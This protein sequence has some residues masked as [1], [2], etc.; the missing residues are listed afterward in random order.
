[1][2]RKFEELEG[3]TTEQYALVPGVAQSR[4]ETN[5]ELPNEIWQTV[6]DLFGADFRPR[7]SLSQVNKR[8]NDLFKISPPQIIIHKNTVAQ[9]ILNLRRISG[10]TFGDA[11]PSLVNQFD[12]HTKKTSLHMMSDNRELIRNAEIHFLEELLGKN[13]EILCKNKITFDVFVLKKNGM[14]VQNEIG[15]YYKDKKGVA[16]LFLIPPTYNSHQGGEIVFF[17]CP[18]QKVVIPTESCVHWQILVFP[19]HVPF[20]IRSVKKGNV[21]I[22]RKRVLLNQLF[23]TSTWVEGI[24]PIS[25]TDPKV[26]VI[27]LSQDFCE[28]FSRAQIMGCPIMVIPKNAYEKDVT[29]NLL[30]EEDRNTY[31]FLLTAW[32]KVHVANLKFCQTF[33]HPPRISEDSILTP[34]NFHLL[35]FTVNSNFH[36]V[37][38]SNF[39]VIHG[40][41]TYDHVM[42]N[43]A[44]FTETTVWNSLDSFWTQISFQ[45]V[46]LIVNCEGFIV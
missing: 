37:K 41:S 17:P 45:L 19:C 33:F 21:T 25:N 44:E 39:F 43:C 7:V 46:V 15:C 29:P 9:Y 28:I 18:G 2:K 11:I 42:R 20:E 35:D 5:R 3:T 22:L 36:S 40:N 23:D 26:S 13:R 34:S 24:L 30:R 27:D 16:T 12:E 8:M 6:C 4:D 1:M 10:F 14:K 32:G 31:N 38:I